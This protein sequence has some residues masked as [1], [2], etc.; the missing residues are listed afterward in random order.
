MRA[1]SESS[2]F[3]KHHFSSSGGIID[4]IKI[5]LLAPFIAQPRAFSIET[6]LDSKKKFREMGRTYV[7]LFKV[8][9]LWPGEQI[10]D[11]GYRR[12][13]AVNYQSY[14]IKSIFFFFK[15]DEYNLLF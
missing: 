5:R 3:L 15:V 1:L 13:R 14:I 8:E 4:D 10:K 6:Y 11:R 9:L 7:R 12:D 2:F